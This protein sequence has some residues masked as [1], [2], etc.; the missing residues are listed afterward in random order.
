MFQYFM[1]KKYSF[2]NPWMNYYEILSTIYLRKL[3]YHLK[4][5][6]CSPYPFGSMVV[7]CKSKL[8]RW[9]S[10]PVKVY[11]ICI[12]RKSAIYLLN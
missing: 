8:V 9:R 7:T 2:L 6:F 10:I 11:S 4:F 3:D 12:Y 5:T 1:C